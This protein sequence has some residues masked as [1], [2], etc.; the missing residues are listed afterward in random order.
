[1]PEKN[2]NDQIQ[3]LRAYLYE[4]FL[5]TM[6]CEKDMKYFWFEIAHNHYLNIAKLI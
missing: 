2:L 1:M 5:M 6:Q 4:V 3:G